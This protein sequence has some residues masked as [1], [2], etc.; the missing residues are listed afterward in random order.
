MLGRVDV[1]VGS[2]LGRKGN[3]GILRRALNPIRLPRWL[4]KEA[5]GIEE[6]EL[7]RGQEIEEDGKG[8]Q[9]GQAQNLQLL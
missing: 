6:E 2:L 8:E 7:C 1:V 4:R 3:W 5:V 9:T